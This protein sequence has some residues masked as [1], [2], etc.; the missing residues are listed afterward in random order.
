VTRLYM[1]AAMLISL[2]IWPLG[3]AAVGPTIS[4]TS[5]ELS[6]EAPTNPDGTTQA[7]LDSYRIYLS[8]TPGD[9]D[10]TTPI[11]SPAKDAT[12]AFCASVGALPLGQW[13][14]VMRSADATGHESANSNEVP[15]EVVL[16]APPDVTAPVVEITHPN[17]GDVVPRKASVPIDVVAS[18]NSGLLMDVVIFVN[19]VSICRLT[20]PPYRC[21]WEVPASSKRTYVLQASAGDFAGNRSLSPTIQ[22]RSE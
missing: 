1:L 12:K 5:C 13:Y 2:L 3:S 20:K 22:V 16:Q 10:F 15:F 7:A 9:Y 11:A 18:D 21:L 19:R 17:K 14:L 6:W 4:P 8:R